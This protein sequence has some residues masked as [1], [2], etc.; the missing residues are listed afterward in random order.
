M[1]LIKSWYIGIVIYDLEG[2]SK[3]GAYIIIVVIL[4][5]VYCHT[6]VYRSNM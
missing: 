2:K 3:Y 6:M 1:K 4:Y 5:Y